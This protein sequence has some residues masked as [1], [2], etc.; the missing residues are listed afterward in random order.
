LLLDHTSG[1][2]VTQELHKDWAKDFWENREKKTKQP[3]VLAWEK[4]FDYE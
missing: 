2:R 4:G 3:N 1:C